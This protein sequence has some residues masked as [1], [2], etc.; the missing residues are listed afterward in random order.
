MKIADMHCDTISRL[1]YENKNSNSKTYTLKTNPFHID[2]EKMKKG[3]YLL[4]NFAIFIDTK[5]EKQ[6]YQAMN[7]MITYF[8][9]ELSKNSKDIRIAKSYNDIKENEKSGIISAILTLEEI[10]YSNGEIDFLQDIYDKG[11]RMLTLTWNYPN[12]LAFPNTH[13]YEK[14]GLTA[15]GIEF[16]QEAQRLGIILDVSHLSDAGFY[17]IVR[18]T[19]KPFVAS[20]SNARG[21]CHHNRNLTDEM[22]RCIGDRGGVIGLN[23]YGMFL[24][25][26]NNPENCISYA[27][28]IAKHAKYIS[29]IG[30]MDCIG[31]GSDFDGISGKLEM[32]DCSKISLLE[33]ALRR[34][35]FTESETEGILYK[36]VLRVYAETIN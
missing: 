32:E 13:G 25:D 12:I 35:G 22:I 28:D 9:G 24:R 3:N 8:Y 5:Y 29:N 2:L 11:V 7:D 17:D 18:I 30:G 34:N 23:Y 26:C 33:S 4:Q 36:N 15:K 10:G 14:N 20:H 19:S 21:L 6:P 16:V 1:Y 27:D 31:L